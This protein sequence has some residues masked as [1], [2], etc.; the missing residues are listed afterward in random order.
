ML[1]K[2]LYLKA[3]G[4]NEYFY[5]WGMEDLERVKRMEILGLPVSRVDGALFHL[6][7]Y[8]YENSWY[9][10]ETLEKESRAEYLKVCSMHKYQLEQYI[11]TWKDV[12]KKYEKY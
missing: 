4:E 1:H 9:Y 5:G 8:R 3:G 7:H 11:Q 10:N 6:F 12:Y 2:D